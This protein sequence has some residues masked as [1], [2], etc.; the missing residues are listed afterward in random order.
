V[1]TRAL[2]IANIG[3]FVWTSLFHVADSDRLLIQYGAFYGPAVQSGEWWRAFTAAFLHGGI[4]HIGFNM[5]ALWQVGSIVEQLFGSWR[6]G[7]VY[8]VSLIGSGWAIYHFN[9]N[10]VTI[11]ASGAIFGLFGA[12]AAAGLRLGRVGRDLVRG[13]LGIILIN[14]I[15][16]FMVPNISQ[17]GHL[18]GLVAGFL[19]GLAVYRPPRPVVPI[20]VDAAAGGEPIEAELLPPDEPQQQGHPR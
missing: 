7:L 6:M 11:G 16:G 15:I 1:L 4:L 19:M 13:M 20:A 17:A 3:V 10:E 8:F 9:Y 12:L 2:L 18:G 14:V 5:F